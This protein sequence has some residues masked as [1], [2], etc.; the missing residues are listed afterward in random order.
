MPQTNTYTVI[1]THTMPTATNSYIF[2]SIPATY[3]DLVLVASVK[4]NNS[5]DAIDIRFNSD[6]SALYSMTA[7]NGNGSAAQS[8]ADANATRLTNMGIT[9]TGFLSSN[10]YHFMSY[11]NTSVFKTVLG[12]SNDPSFR[13]AGI[14]GLWRSTSA[15]NSIQ[16][17]SD[18]A[19]YSF[20]AGSTFT[21]YG[22]VAA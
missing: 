1:A 18:N 15:I 19:G 21:L 2:T 22:I 6:G 10:I 12:R 8:F 14:V 9:T 3:T 13:V 4:N 17:Y 20:A 16:L 7:F 5:T 11:A